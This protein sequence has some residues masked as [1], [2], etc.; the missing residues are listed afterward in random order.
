[1]PEISV[2]MP[3]FNARPWIEAAIKSLQSQTLRDFELIVVDDGSTDGTGEFVRSIADPRFR[4]VRQANAGT[5]AAMNRCIAEARSPLLARLDADDIAHPDRLMRQLAFMQANPEVV[6]VGTQFRF[7]VSD[8]II[9]APRVPLDH[10]EIVAAFL[11][12]RGAMCN[13][14]L[15][16]RTAT[17][18]DAGGCQFPLPGEDI[19]LC[20]RLSQRGRVANIPEVLQQYRLHEQSAVFRFAEPI[21]MGHAF[22]IRCFR[23]RANGE[24]EPTVEGFTADWARRPLLV[25]L[26]DWRMQRSTQNYRRS[27]IRRAQ[28][29][30]VSAA[31]Q[32]AVAA[33]Y[34]PVAAIKKLAGGVS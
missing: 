2:C 33:V 11:E 6:V 9:P 28:G 19:D 1:M 5:G 23:C 22:A 24:P 32:L 15:V 4:V 25:R 13:S 7:L 31:A 18:R 14:S 34:R 8:R 21:L 27:L 20:L 30:R 26:S 3:A 12:R 16:M 17:V 29:R 10:D